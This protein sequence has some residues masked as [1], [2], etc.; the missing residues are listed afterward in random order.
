M[1]A[2]LPQGSPG[3][4][5]HWKLQE[6]PFLQ[7]LY[8]KLTERIN[9]KRGPMSLSKHSLKTW[10]LPGLEIMINELT[11]FQSQLTSQS[12]SSQ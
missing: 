9:S 7:N 3:A 6:L 8:A 11:G 1:I 12:K 4:Y 2:R 10:F 5:G